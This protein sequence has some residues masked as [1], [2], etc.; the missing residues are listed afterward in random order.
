[1]K[2]K[3]I[4]LIMVMV[5]SVLTFTGCSAFGSKETTRYTCNGE[6]IEETYVYDGDGNVVEHYIANVVVD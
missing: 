5:I 4:A 6:T 3:F 1:M 2:M